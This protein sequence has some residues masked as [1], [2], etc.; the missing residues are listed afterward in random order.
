M[1]S[2]AIAPSRPATGTGRSPRWTSRPYGDADREAVLG[3]FTEPDFFFRTA[4][5]DTRP[6]WEI[7]EL[8]D[9]T[10]VLLADGEPVGLW[11]VEDVS[12]AHSC[13]LQLHLRLTAAAPAAWWATAYTEVIRALRWRREVVRLTVQIGEYDQ[14]GLAT[15]RGLGFTEEG[16]LAEVVVREGRRYGYVYFSRIWTPT[17]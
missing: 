15:L 16:T 5:P 3:F 1:T 12:V 11:A 9:D 13:H 10:E 6:E 4:A 8:L 14:R 17:S 2:P 7:L